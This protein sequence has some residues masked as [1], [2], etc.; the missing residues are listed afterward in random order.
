MLT[1]W[2]TS[3]DGQ[4]GITTFY[5][6]TMFLRSGRISA[7]YDGGRGAGRGWKGEDERKVV[8]EGIQVYTPH[9]LAHSLTVESHNL[10]HNKP[11][12][13]SSPPTLKRE[14]KKKN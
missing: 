6:E 7:D 4:P 2:T 3:A 11:I 9:P 1:D 13:T 14:R 5:V 12:S 10:P 8:D